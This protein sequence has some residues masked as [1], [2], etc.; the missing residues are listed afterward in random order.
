M[1]ITDSQFRKGRPD[2]TVESE[3]LRFL[4][5]NPDLAYAADEIADGI[6]ALRRFNVWS[7]YVSLLE[8]VDTLGEMAAAGKVRTKVV[9]HARYYRATPRKAQRK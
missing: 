1:P 2:S 3:I 5:L 6:E 8:V 7:D 4:A 9:L